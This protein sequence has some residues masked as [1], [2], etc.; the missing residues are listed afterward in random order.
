[1]KTTSDEKKRTIVWN[2]A[3]VWP[4]DE[5]QT[6]RKEERKRTGEIRRFKE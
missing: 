6:C 2:V 3:L 5:K 1:M 4:N